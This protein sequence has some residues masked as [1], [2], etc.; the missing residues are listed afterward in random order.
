MKTPDTSEKPITVAANGASYNLTKPFI[1]KQIL[2]IRCFHTYAHIAEATELTIRFTDGTTLKV[3]AKGKGHICSN[4]IRE[5]DK[6]LAN[7]HAV[8]EPFLEIK[9][10]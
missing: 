7:P 6:H 5:C 2:E 4:A 3:V 1:G 8:C 9:K 10:L